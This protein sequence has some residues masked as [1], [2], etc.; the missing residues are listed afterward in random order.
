MHKGISLKKVVKKTLAVSAVCMLLGTSIQLVYADEK[1][2]VNVDEITADEVSDSGANEYV[3]DGHYLKQ[4]KIN[5][6]VVVEN[7]YDDSGMRIAKSG[8]D[9]CHFEY[10]ENK[11]L[12][13][14][15]RNGKVITYFYEKDKEYEYW[16]ITGFNYGGANYYYTRDNMSRIDGIQ[17]ESKELVA[18]YEYG[19]EKFKVSKVMMKQGEEWV[20]TD[21]PEF[22]GNV[23]KI[24]NRD[25]YYDDECDLYYGCNG[26][27]YSPITGYVIMNVDESIDISLLSDSYDLDYNI[28]CWQQSLLE[29]DSFNAELSKTADWHT[30]L[31]DVAVVA[32][33]IYGEN[34]SVASDQ[35]AIANVIRNRAVDKGKKD[36]TKSAGELARA[37]VLEAGQFS[38]AAPTDDVVS[39]KKSYDLGWQ[40]AVHKACLLCLTL[41]KED[42][43]SLNSIPYGMGEQK[44]FRSIKNNYSNFSGANPM[45]YDKGTYHTDAYHAYI[46][47]YGE[48]N[49]YSTLYSIKNNYLDRNIYFS[50]YNY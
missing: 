46:A 10:D 5:G 43:D 1:S 29:D 15:E 45:H 11:N 50:E 42:W 40:N 20:G 33:I 36:N 26:V 19:S 4:V 21:E 13:R 35:N 37:V 41:D 12:I 25:S 48:V 28:Y 31:S 7:Y 27:F 17:S 38:T 16:H 22:V 39:E 6:K 30:G 3:F 34:T 14:E 47:G 24:R 49:S 44:C 23:N 18:K 32:R 8:A 9:E 2:K